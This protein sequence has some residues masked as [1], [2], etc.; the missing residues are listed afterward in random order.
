[1]T[2]MR[3]VNSSDPINIDTID[4]KNG[5]IYRLANT[6]YVTG[7]FPSNINSKSGLL[8]GF[9]NISGNDVGLQMYICYSGPNLFIRQGRN[10]TD[11]SSWYIMSKSVA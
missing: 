10:G 7:T 11:W 2:A 5:Y 4:N 3:G 8:I 6:Q 1:M 9:S